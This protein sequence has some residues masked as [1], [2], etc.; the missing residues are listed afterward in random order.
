[1]YDDLDT[2]YA[3]AF[4]VD[5]QRQLAAVQLE[6]GQI[7]RGRS[8][9]RYF[10]FRGALLPLVIPGAALVTQNRPDGL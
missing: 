4:G 5:L 2:K 9:D 8:L 3:F 10:P 7:L 1:V 6:D